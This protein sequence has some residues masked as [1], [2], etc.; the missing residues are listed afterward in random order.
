MARYK[1][2]ASGQDT[3]AAACPIIII[4]LIIETRLYSQ[5]DI[6]VVGRMAGVEMSVRTHEEEGKNG[7]PSSC[8]PELQN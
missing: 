6:H 4:I 1:N 7:D 5:A 8:H 3:I 2:M